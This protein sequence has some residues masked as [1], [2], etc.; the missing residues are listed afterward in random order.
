MSYPVVAEGSVYVSVRNQPGYGTQIKALDAA[1]GAVRWTVPNPG[2]YWIGGLAY[3]AGRLIVLGGGGDLRA[4]A[5]AAGGGV[6]GIKLGEAAGVSPPGAHDG[7]GYV[8][9]GGSGAAVFGAH[10]GAGGGPW[11]PNKPGG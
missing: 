11:G 10:G 5:P 2:V 8:G 4:L 1:T 9:G 3:D 7:E 6:W